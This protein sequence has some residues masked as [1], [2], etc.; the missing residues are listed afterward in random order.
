MMRHCLPVLL[1]IVQVSTTGAWCFS[2]MLRSWEI[3]ERGLNLAERVKLPST[4]LGQGGSTPEE[5]TE[6]AFRFFN[7]CCHVM[8]HT[9]RGSINSLSDEDFSRDGPQW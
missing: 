4:R 6:P 2:A 3:C 9:D 1:L 8:H 7:F 5:R